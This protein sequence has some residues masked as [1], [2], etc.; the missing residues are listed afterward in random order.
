MTGTMTVEEKPVR[1]VTLGY[2]DADIANALGAEIVGSV[3]SPFGSDGVNPPWA[4]EPLPADVANLDVQAPN[5][6]AIAAADPDII[7]AMG[8]YPSVI[9]LY[10]SLSEIAPVLTPTT[11][12]LLD[13]A[14][15]VTTTIGRALG[16]SEAA[17]ALLAEADRAIDEFKAANPG[18]EGKTAV[19]APR[20]GTRTAVFID[21]S[22][23][24]VTLLRRL[25]LTTPDELVSLPGE[26]TFGATF[27]SDEELSLLDSADIAIV[28]LYTEDARSAFL[29]MPLVA[30]LSVT[31]DERLVPI[32][33]SLGAAL[34]TPNPV[35]IQYLLSELGPQLAAAAG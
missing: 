34:Q 2:T 13:S 8:A 3:A 31:T 27:I 30:G 4:V 14:E 23:A 22:A 5:L 26:Q 19:F 6:E 17:A 7:L 28:G 32:D 25:G 1:V 12:P 9:E 11:G 24:S 16:E 18:L 15:D 21:E 33:I 20:E 29:A 35:S 10:D